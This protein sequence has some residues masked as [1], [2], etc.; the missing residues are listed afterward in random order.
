MALLIA[1][2]G[3]LPRV[4]LAKRQA[5]GWKPYQRL[6]GDAA[7]L[8]QGA[9]SVGVIFCQPWLQW[10]VEQPAGVAGFR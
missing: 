7:A 3:A 9:K 1:L 6:W 8:P 4:A 10:V 2:D 5:G